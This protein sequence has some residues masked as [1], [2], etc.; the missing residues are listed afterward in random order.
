MKFNSVGEFV[1]EFVTT[2]E[3]MNVGQQ[4]DDEVVMQAALVA[5]K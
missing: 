1:E 3:E 4:M 2:H 5:Q